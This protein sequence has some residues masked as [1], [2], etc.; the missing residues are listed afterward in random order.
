MTD[1][2]A[3]I[4]VD[5]QHDFLPGG[6][7]AVPQGFEVI[8]PI[9]K[10]AGEFRHIAATQ[11]WH[12]AVHFSFASRHGKSPFEQ[13]ETDGGPQVLWP[14]H[15]I[16][17]TPGAQIHPEILGLKPSVLIRKGTNPETDSYSAFFDNLKKH[18]TPLDSWLREKNI[19]RIVVAGLATDFCVKFTVLDGLSLGYSV[20]VFLPGCRGINPD[21]ST[22]LK[23]ME[24][25]GA[26]FIR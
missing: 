10:L 16:Q 14:D 3:L 1:S 23:E 25:A 5:V 13:I 20:Q 24:R 19:R 4:V 8:G 22:D 15:C 12:P 26:E 6:A 18:Q 2:Q 21:L 7:L 11:D 17:D 9:T